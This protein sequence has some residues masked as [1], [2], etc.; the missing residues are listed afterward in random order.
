MPELNETFLR[1]L[2]LTWCPLVTLNTYFKWTSF[3]CCLIFDYT[4]SWNLRYWYERRQRAIIQ[5]LA[6]WSV[7]LGS[8]LSA[9]SCGFLR[10]L[11]LT[12]AARL[13]TILTRPKQ[14][15]EQMR[16]HLLSFTLH[17]HKYCITNWAFWKSHVAYTTT[18]DIFLQKLFLWLSIA[19]YRV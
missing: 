18:P 5:T 3:N 4:I 15:P 10:R 14:P 1:Y 19:V 13:L 17:R 9:L 6:Y 7:V 16:L 8:L 11:K 12:P 2:R